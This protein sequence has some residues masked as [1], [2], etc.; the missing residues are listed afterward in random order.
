MSKSETRLYFD[1]ETTGLP[2]W[3]HPIDHHSQPFV[4]QVA[5]LMTRCD[6]VL[7][8][9][10][11]ILWPREVASIPEEAFAVHGIST[12]LMETY[13]Q[14]PEEVLWPFVHAL[15][16]ADRVIAHNLPFDMF[17][18][19]VQF[20]RL[21]IV[22]GTIEQ[23]QEAGY[24]RRIA[25]DAKAMFKKPTCTMKLATPVLEL[26]PTAR[27]IRAGHG[28]KFKSPRLEQAYKHF[29]GMKLVGAHDAS[30]DV[31]ACRV[32]YEHLVGERDGSAQHELEF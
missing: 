16:R 24:A 8:Q 1:T 9:A 30:V 13:G 15:K 22:G 14:R 12:D 17:L 5:W 4:V 7:E 28:G 32:V 18:M 6:R 2:Q 27:M 29:T 23:T 19:S 31:D 20:A 3:G 21:G 10:N 26:P 25:D 11:F